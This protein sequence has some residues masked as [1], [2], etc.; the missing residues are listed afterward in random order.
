MGH[1]DFH[2]PPRQALTS[3]PLQDVHVRQVRIRRSI[4]DDAREA[5]LLSVG[6]HTKAERAANRTLD[7]GTRYAGR[8]VGVGEE[9]MDRV[10]IEARGIGGNGK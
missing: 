7:Y 9:G 2:Q 3:V 1:D 4:G 6:V 5:N 8:P 10:E